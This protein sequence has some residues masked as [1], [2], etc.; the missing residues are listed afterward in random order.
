MAGN[1]SASDRFASVILPVYNQ[2]DHI[3]RV[4][5]EYDTALTTTLRIQHE[6]ILV[7]NGSTDGSY[8]ACCDIAK[9][10]EHVRAIQTAQQGWGLAVK[11]GIAEARG[12]VLCYTNSARTTARDL[13]MVLLHASLDPNVVVKAARKIRESGLRRFGSLLYALECRAL[14]DLANWDING[15]P[16]AFPRRFERLLALTRNDDLIDLEFNVICRQENY[17]MLEVPIFSRSR[18]GG[19]STTSLESAWRLYWGAYRM[20]RQ[21]KSALPPDDGGAGR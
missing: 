12:D 16:K 2:A 19:R 4:V 3:H 1:T 18:H 9:R 14:F 11:T 8:E 13:A 6:L 15:T 10:I 5:S 21:L 20:W 17:P 7:V